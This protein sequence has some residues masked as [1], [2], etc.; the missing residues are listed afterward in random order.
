MKGR[1]LAFAAGM[2]LLL[3]GGPAG[4]GPCTAEIAKLEKALSKTD[5]G[6]RPVASSSAESNAA[7]GSGSGT[8][9]GT[10]ATTEMNAA[11]QGNATSTQDVQ[12][13]N[14][15]QPTAADAAQAN[16]VAPAAGPTKASATLQ[17]AKELDQAGKE[18][19]CMS[20]VQQAKEQM[21]AEVH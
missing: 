12:N 15:G 9:S 20:T 5:A 4:A 17:R 6:I 10:G 2:V 13:Q 16:E 3:A 8:M 7:Q 19:E 1:F 11:S 21:G 14:Q 18:S